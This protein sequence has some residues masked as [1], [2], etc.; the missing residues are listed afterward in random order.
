MRKQSTY[1]FNVFDDC[2]YFNLS[3]LT[4]S[5]TDIWKIE[6][7]KLGLSPS[8]GYLLFA[9]VESKG[10]QQK[11]Y[12]EHLDLDASTVNRLVDSLVQKK[13]V[14]KEGAGRGS[15]VSV[16]AEG[17][18]EYRR[19]KKTMD[20]LRQKISNSLGEKRF[21]QLVGDLVSTRSA[22]TR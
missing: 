22:L 4:R 2:L 20:N 5:I 8:H 10:E 9:M 3:S 13:L 12:G 11:D 19:I 16:T 21:N 15:E 6:F 1:L 14:A 18:R 17:R 7:A